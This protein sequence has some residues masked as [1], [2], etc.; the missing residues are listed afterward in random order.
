MQD[1]CSMLDGIFVP[2]SYIF[3]N[4]FSWL[5]LVPM[6]CFLERSP[7]VPFVQDTFD[8]LEAC[9]DAMAICQNG[10]SVHTLSL[11]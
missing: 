8:I 5:Y 7:D 9:I 4:F 6:R 1:K 2:P 11:T 3:F 10:A